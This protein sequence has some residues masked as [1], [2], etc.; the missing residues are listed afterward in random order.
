M[1]FDHIAEIVAK[2]CL[3][4]F[5]PNESAGRLALM[6]I[7]GG[8]ASDEDQV[9]W[10]V[11]SALAIY[12][13]WPGPRELRAL[14]CSRWTPRDGIKAYSQI[15]PSDEYGGGFPAQ[16]YPPSKHPAIPSPKQVRQ[17][18]SAPIAP[19]SQAV[20]DGEKFRQM[21]RPL[22]LGDASE[23]RLNEVLTAPADRP[24]PPLPTPQII[25]QAD[26]DREVAALRQRKRDA[27]AAAASVQQ[28]AYVLRSPRPASQDSGVVEDRPV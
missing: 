16:I 5:F 22:H 4:K 1:E 13:E 23:K 21:P 2:L 6:E 14:F 8:M 12:D 27:F 10:L 19:T 11:K 24:L 28:E 7:I 26:I 17:I 20:V 18:E 3:L 9:R 15:Y 25:K